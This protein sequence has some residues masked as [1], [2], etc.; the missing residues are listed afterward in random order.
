MIITSTRHAREA[1]KAGMIFNAYSDYEIKVLEVGENDVKCI[2][3][4]YNELQ[5]YKEI[6]NSYYRTFTDFV[7]NESINV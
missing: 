5:E 6:G 3:V 1:L 2:D 7:G 4:D